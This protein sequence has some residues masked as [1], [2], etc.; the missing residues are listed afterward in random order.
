MPFVWNSLH[1]NTRVPRWEM[2]ETSLKRSGRAPLDIYIGPAP[3][4]QSAIPNLRKIM[5]MLIPHLGRWRTLHLS[6]AP[7]KVR[8]VLLDQ[9]G[10]KP[11]PHLG[12]I[13]ITRIPLKGEPY[14]WVFPSSSPRCPAQNVFAGFPNLKCVEWTSFT[15]DP[16]NLPSFKNLKHLTIGKGTFYRILPGPFT[17][18]VHRILSD[19]PS[20]SMFTIYNIP[21]GEGWIAEPIESLPP[22]LTHH[23]LQTLVIDSSSK[24]RAAVIR[25]LILPKLRTYL[26]GHS[27]QE[28]NIS[29]CRIIARENS[30]P[31]LRG[32]ALYGDAPLLAEYF[33]VPSVQ[34]YMPFLRPAIQNLAQLRVL[35]FEAV[36]FDNE[37]WLPDLGTCCPHLRQLRFLWCPG[38]TIASIR[39]LVETRIHQDGVTPLEYLF[40]GH[41]PS[42]S[43]ECKLSEEDHAWFSKRLKFGHINDYWYYDTEL[44]AW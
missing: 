39:L 42:A 31:E 15:Y 18:L 29:C 28:V 35:G 10:G 12:D 6:E 4:V 40:V 5:R 24:C 27:L 8:R 9:I 41:Q 1:V 30:L 21:D 32:I 11:A 14:E 16:K 37:R 44:K 22:T 43:P 13:K 3:F 36:N 26:K 25:T 2:L 38:V 34:A 17:Q 20:L 33:P 19:S 23:S 7:F